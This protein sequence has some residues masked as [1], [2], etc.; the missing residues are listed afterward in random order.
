MVASSL[1]MLILRTSERP[2]EEGLLYGCAECG[3]WIGL[4]R[5]D[6]GD[7]TDVSTFKS[8]EGG[9]YLVAVLR[10]VWPRQ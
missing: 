5:G 10:I 1:S 6:E 9:R 2:L 8:F 4:Y 7:N 3:R